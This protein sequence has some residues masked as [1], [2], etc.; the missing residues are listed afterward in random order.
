MYLTPVRVSCG[1]GTDNASPSVHWSERNRT[2]VIEMKG[3][4]PIGTIHYWLRPER[5]SCAVIALKIAEPT[6]RNRGFGTEAQ[7]YL[8]IHLMQRMK[9]Q[10]VEMYT[11]V[12]NMP[13]QRCLAKLG[14]ELV[15]SLQ[16]E[17]SG[18]HRTGHL[19]RLDRERFVRTSMYHFH[20][21]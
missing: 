19:Y 11:D 9:L 3:F 10:E 1:P 13:Q 21:E 2:F 7:K 8:I 5:Q 12:R 15:E 18:V 20:Y 4:A 17:D 14:F 16:Y 6:L